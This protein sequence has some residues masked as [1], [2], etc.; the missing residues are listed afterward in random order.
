MKISFLFI[1]IFFTCIQ[2]KTQIKCRYKA[3]EFEEYKLGITSDQGG[4][5]PNAFTIYKN[6]LQLETSFSLAPRT[7]RNESEVFASVSQIRYGI[8]PKFEARLGYNYVYPE[9]IETD[10]GTHSQL[11]LGL[12][13]R[14]FK[15]GADHIQWSTAFMGNYFI[16]NLKSLSESYPGGYYALVNNTLS[17]YHLVD[18]D[19]T[20]G[21]LHNMNRNTWLGLLSTQLQ[22]KPTESM[23]GFFTGLGGIYIESYF[24]AGILFTDNYNFL[25][26]LG[27]MATDNA[28]TLNVCYTHCFKR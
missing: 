2:G 18:L 17:F 11:L 1:L 3:A 27:I 20:F 4:L 25:L 16:E 21:F 7:K 23:W 22:I 6:D 14:L 12:K 13:V 26:Q 24:S 10:T 8:N 15:A 28:N 9:E 19:I 5:F